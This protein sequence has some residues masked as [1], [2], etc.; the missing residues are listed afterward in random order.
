MA[1]EGLQKICC[2]KGVLGLM[3]WRT[4]HR[5]SPESWRSLRT[6]SVSTGYPEW[7]TP[8]AEFSPSHIDKSCTSGTGLLCGGGRVNPGAF[9]NY[10]PSRVASSTHVQI[11]AHNYNFYSCKITE[12]DKFVSAALL[13]L[14][15]TPVLVLSMSSCGKLSPDSSSVGSGLRP[16]LIW[17]P[18]LS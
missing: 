18:A 3:G 16:T 13:P 7:E 8:R 17:T 12:Q 1:K 10:I 15:D 11:N 9:D 4:C 5:E 2:K 14:F 6:G